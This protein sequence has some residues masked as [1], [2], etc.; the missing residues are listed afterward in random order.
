[1]ESIGGLPAHPLFVHAPVVLMPLAAIAT[2]V[3][4]LRPQWRRRSGVVLPIAAV[5]ILVLTQ[6][7]ISSGDAFDEIVGDRVDTTDHRA[8]A[9]TTR[10]FIVMFAVGAIA[11]AALDRWRDRSAPQWLTALHGLAIGVSVVGAALAT[12]WMVRTGDEGAR[13]VWDGVISSIRLWQ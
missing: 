8:L 9:L 2:I 7:T 13:L 6:L 1:M 10:W 12:V 4:A 5:A 11:T 3:L